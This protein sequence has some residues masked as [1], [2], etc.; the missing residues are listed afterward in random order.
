MES[1]IK[2]FEHALSA[3]DCRELIHY[4]LNENS[5]SVSLDYNS[6]KRI[7]VIDHKIVCRLSKLCNIDF[8]RAFIMKYDAGIGSPLHHD[9]YSIE[10]SENV[11]N[12][13]R[14]SGVVFLNQEFD[15]GE[16]V[17]PNQGIAI[18]P[19]VG[20]MVIAPADETAPHFVNPPS[21][22]RYVLVLRI[23]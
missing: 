9:N 21:S 6:L 7:K 4:L 3:N 18:K 22:D 2:I 20:N 23:I 12:A 13:W 1:N 15:G 10:N 8:D 14:Y 5:D 11:Y 19:V 17:Y 16:L